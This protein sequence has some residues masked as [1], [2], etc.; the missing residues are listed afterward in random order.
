MR[1]SFR[2]SSPN[3]DRADAVEILPPLPVAGPAAEGPDRDA[4]RAGRD[5]VD[6]V[7][8][9]L[10]RAAR[11]VGVAARDGCAETAAAAA[12]AAALAR[13][14]EALGARAGE[15]GG[16][17]R[18]LGISAETLATES[19]GLAGVLVQA[20]RHLARTDAQSRMLEAEMAAAAQDAARVVE[21]AA[22]LARQA[23]RLAL[24][25][26]VE[27]ARAGTAGGPLWQMAEEIKLL[28]G[29]AARAVEE[30]RALS[31]RLSG[32]GAVAMGS[33]ATSLAC[34]R[35]AFATTGTAAGAQADAARRLAGEAQAL[36]DAADDL[37]HD[38]AAAATAAG[39]A[40]RRMQ[41]AES[42]GAGV[43]GLAGGLA[44]RTVASLRQAEI[45]DR[46]VHDRYP[47]DLSA[48]VGN[49]GLGRVLDLSRGGLL[50]TPP[51]G[52]GAATGARL[53][54]DL[55][56]IGRIQVQVV[57]TSPRGLHCTF[58]PA[59]EARMR[60]AL[61]AIEEENRPLIAGVQ[62]GAEAV[63]GALEQ[64]LAAGRLAHHALFDTRYR[65]VAGI[66]P[67]HYLTAAVPA[68]EDI[69]PPILEPLL[70]ADPRTAFCIAVDRNG[71][72][73]VH[74]RAQAQAPRTGDPAWNALHARQRRLYDDRIGLSAA[75][76]TRAFLVQACPQDEAG[77]QPL[78]EVAAPVRVHGRHWGAL[79]MGFRI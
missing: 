48:R 70:L 10:V 67:P 54:L 29:D 31:R 55:R 71:Y 39:E 52:C 79:R 36:A 13:S 11:A 16:Q 17:G 12:D 26:T 19:E 72:A 20:G 68:L 47:V 50:L 6:R 56:G 60:D 5:A 37:G 77:R 41:A 64:A 49:W 33:V 59:S 1:L 42:V 34:L 30:V 75:R 15:A 78:R 44:G 51:E 9:E 4:G 23:N 57:G 62:G 8:A 74:N 65:P 32:P 61:V 53:S 35:P 45:G 38:A 24:N 27:A 40:A 73:P 63:G 43:A 3:R 76:S 69:L 22:T 2:P 18:A 66:E 21:A 25:A 14:L 46:R 28:S 58:D 7:E